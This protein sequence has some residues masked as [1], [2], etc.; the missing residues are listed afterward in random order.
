MKVRFGRPHAR[1]SGDDAFELLTSQYRAAYTRYQGLT[2][3]NT[4]LSLTGGKPS[5]QARLDEE[6]AFEQLDVARHAL[7]NATALSRPTVH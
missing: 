1:Q 4:E 5:A 6:C 2:D 3:K 7:M